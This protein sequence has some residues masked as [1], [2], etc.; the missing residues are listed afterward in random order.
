MRRPRAFALTLSLLFAAAPLFADWQQPDPSYRDAQFA[1]RAALRDTVGQGGNAAR[2]DTLAVAH[3]RLDHEA[4]ARRLFTRVLAANPAD[5]AA[6]AGLA[7]LALFADR[8]AEAESLLAGALL[9]DDTAPFDLLAA[10]IRLGAYADAAAL[11]D[12]LGLAGRADMLRRMAEGGTYAI[13][14]APGAKLM[15]VR[16]LPVP[17]LRVKLN[18]QSV[19]MA[20][21]PGA[22][23]LLVDDFVGR[24]CKVTPSPIQTLVSWDGTRVSVKNTVVKRLELGGVRIENLPAGVLPLRRWGLEVNPQGERVAG[25][26]G[27]GVLSRFA[28]VL[29]LHEGRFELA[30][31]GSALAAAPDARHIPFQLWGENE[32]MVRGSI[33]GGRAMA[34]RVTTGIPGCGIAAPAEVFEE[35]G[36]RAGVLARMMRGAGAALAGA[37]WSQVSASSVTVGPLSRDRITGWSG[38][39]DSSELWRH[40]VRRDAALSTDFFRDLRVGIDWKRHELL[41]EGD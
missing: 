40:G 27:A 25:V 17:L 23:D 4:D 3:L 15:F 18:G 28:T 32:I 21:D 20:V 5:A 24:Q 10:R 30:P 9:A 35:L 16:L 6:R 8:P 34:M 26:I 37:P 11:A 12:S 31:S 38:A 39:M 36:I 7:K 41:I 13:S 22:G 1:L 29:D 33:A 14:G 2:L 19:L